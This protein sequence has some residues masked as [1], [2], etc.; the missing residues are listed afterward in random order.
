M[1]S[2]NMLVLI[3]L[4]AI[5][6][7]VVCVLQCECGLLNRLKTTEDSGGGGGGGGGGGTVLTQLPPQHMNLSKKC[8]TQTCRSEGKLYHN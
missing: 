2:S 5:I 8:Y 6:F 4:F 3:E 1:A 7:M